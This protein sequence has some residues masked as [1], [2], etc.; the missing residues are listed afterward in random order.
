M[1]IKVQVF[2]PKQ[3]VNFSALSRV[4]A[5]VNRILIR[6]DALDKV[7]LTH[8]RPCKRFTFVRKYVATHAQA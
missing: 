6:S 5:K 3:R 7:N 8:S 2:A 1:N 4:K